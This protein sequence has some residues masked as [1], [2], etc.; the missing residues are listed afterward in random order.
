M[1][2]R[3]SKTMSDRMRQLTGN[4]SR[5][6]ARRTGAAPVPLA[7]APKPPVWLGKDGAAVWLK[8]AA[9]LIQRRMLAASD[10]PAFAVLVSAVVDHRQ[11]TEILAAEGLITSAGTG[12]LKAHPATAL[13]AQ[14]ATL[15]L[16]FAGEFGLSPSAR[17]S[18]IGAATTSDAGNDRELKYFA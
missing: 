5:T 15:I 17:Q 1:G 16:R 12:A 6:P 10:L 8:L 7:R 14:A 18:L 9:D 3:G 11:A 13:K 4:P 2:R